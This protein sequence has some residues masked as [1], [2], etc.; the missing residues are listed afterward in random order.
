[1]GATLSQWKESGPSS[2]L[3]IHGKRQY[4]PVLIILRRLMILLFLSG[5]WQERHLVRLTLTYFRLENLRTYGIVQL[6]HHR[7]H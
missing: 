7:E 5:R 4:G 1:M 2:L 6:D 3:W